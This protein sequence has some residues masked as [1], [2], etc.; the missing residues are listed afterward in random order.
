LSKG[1]RWN[2]RS[3][4]L[5]AIYSSECAIVTSKHLKT[6]IFERFETGEPHSVTHT[7][8]DRHP[9]LLIWE[10]IRRPRAESQSVIRSAW[11]PK[12][13][14]GVVL[15]SIA[16]TVRL[17]LPSEAR[18]PYARS[19]MGARKLFQT[20]SRLPFFEAPLV[21]FTNVDAE[22][23]SCGGMRGSWYGGC[24]LRPR[25]PLG[26]GHDQHLWR[27]TPALADGSCCSC[28]TAG[29]VLCCNHC[30]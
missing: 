3:T 14:K 12:R 13:F 7:N 24:V 9:T 28:E 22:S 16:L 21:S 19:F 4:K 23:R 25:E 15:V 26:L 20:H 18:R 6:K 10:D 5:I 8:V 17:R 30:I 2:N 29:W 27:T 1:R 11:L